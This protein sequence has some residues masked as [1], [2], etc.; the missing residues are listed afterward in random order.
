M[1]LILI[2]LNHKTAPVEVRERLSVNPS[3]EPELIASL[4]RVP[5]VRGA[6]VLSTCNRVEIILSSDSEES[7][8]PVVDLIV[9]RSDMKRTEV[10]GHLYALRNGDV[11]RHLFRVAS[12]L[13]SMIVGEPQIGGQVREA[14]QRSRTLHA[15]DPILRQ[16]FDAALRVAKRVRTDTGIGEHAV[17]VPFAA[18]ELARKI[19]GDLDGLQVLLVG[20]GEIGELTAQHLNAYG[21]RKV[22]V[23]NRAHDRA[24]ELA[25][26]FEGEAIHFDSLEERLQSCE[27][28][29]VSTAAPH[30]LIRP[31]HVT[32]ALAERRRGSLFLIDLSV[33]RN[34]D[35]AIAGIEGAFLYNID[36]LREVAD[37]NRERREQKAV[38]A[39]E[40]IDR[41]VDGFMRRLASHDAVPTILELQG[42]LEDI[43]KME[44][45]KCLRRVGPITTEQQQAIEALSTSIINKVLHYPI[46]RLKETAATDQPEERESIREQI[47]RIF[48][49]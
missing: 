28:V 37:S 33:P 18:V 8:E 4:T 29:I 49:L 48:G 40:I 30:Y 17:S 38:T 16:L 24:L 1:S 41:E 19:F 43:R 46:I 15:T 10:E 22:F 20:A 7:I 25:R 44:L 9:S 26:R 32:A 14:Y 47:R 5:G 21:L 3:H 35:P 42:K 12:G 39:E 11:V 27:I 13:D 45:E 6:G 36:D 23:A 31:E 2:G 34:I